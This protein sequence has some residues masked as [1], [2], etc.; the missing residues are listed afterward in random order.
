MPRRVPVP[1]TEFQL[2]SIRNFGAKSSWQ[3][4]CSILGRLHLSAWGGAGW[5]HLFWGMGQ[6]IL[7]VELLSWSKSVDYSTKHELNE[8]SSQDLP[9]TVDMEDLWTLIKQRHV[10]SRNNGASYRQSLIFLSDNR[11]NSHINQWVLKLLSFVIHS[12]CFVDEFVSVVLSLDNT[13]N[14]KNVKQ[15]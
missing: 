4:V 9:Q 1:W 6:S 8:F 11:R 7:S 12:M 5:R 10:I 13:K 14:D 15:T 3:V 2:G